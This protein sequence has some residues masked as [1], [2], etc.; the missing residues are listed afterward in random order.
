[1]IAKYT[2]VWQGGVPEAQW[3]KGVWGTDLLASLISFCVID[4]TELGHGP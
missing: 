1:M 3:K 4:V 2:F